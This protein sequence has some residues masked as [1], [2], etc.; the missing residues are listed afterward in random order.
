MLFCFSISESV[1]ETLCITVSAFVYSIIADYKRFTYTRVSNGDQ[2]LLQGIKLTVIGLNLGNLNIFK[3][4]SKLTITICI[5]ATK[6]I[7]TF[8]SITQ[9]SLSTK[10]A[11]YTYF[12]PY[13]QYKFYNTS[14]VNSA[15][16]NAIVICCLSEYRVCQSLEQGVN[17]YIQRKDV[18]LVS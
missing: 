5:P 6:F 18:L 17:S 13:I 7:G 4:Q 10:T 1:E 8:Y 2:N 14:C 11:P 12:N 16:C 3:Q 9:I 15:K